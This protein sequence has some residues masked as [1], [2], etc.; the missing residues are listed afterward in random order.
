MLMKRQCEEQDG[1]CCPSTGTLLS[2]GLFHPLQPDPTGLQARLCAQPS[3]LTTLS[4]LSHSGHTP[5]TVTGTNLDVIQEPRIR[6]KHNG[7]EFVNVSRGWQLGD[8]VCHGKSCSGGV[9]CAPP[10]WGHWEEGIRCTKM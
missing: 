4:C 1:C 9:S 3:P 7:R 5:L 10:N 8:G 6:V 2:P